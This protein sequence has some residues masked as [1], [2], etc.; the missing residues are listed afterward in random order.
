MSKQ[1]RALF[2]AM[3][4]LTGTGVVFDDENLV[5]GGLL[6]GLFM[7]ISLFAQD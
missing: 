4:I 2:W 7:Y 6:F 1:T 5:A 3:V